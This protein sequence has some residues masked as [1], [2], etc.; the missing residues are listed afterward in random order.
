MSV[1]CDMLLHPELL[2][3]SQLIALIK[4]RRL[5]IPDVERMHRDELLQV[6]HSYCVPYGQR[7]YRDTG[8]GKILNQARNVS[9]E[10]A[11]KLNVFNDSHHRKISHMDNCE[12][13]KPPP[14]LL[15]GHLKRIK[16]DIKPVSDVISSKRKMSIDS[17]S[18]LLKYKLNKV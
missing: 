6:F 11:V 9:S 12:R 16:L 4:E 13:L 3:N 15:S 18:V 10:P 8:R 7:K 14:D 17:V 2:S 1:P 5:H